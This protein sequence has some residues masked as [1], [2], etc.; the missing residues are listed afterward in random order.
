MKR[1]FLTLFLVIV[2]A[3]INESSFASVNI[4]WTEN[5]VEFIKNNPVINIGVDPQF[6]PFEFIDEDGNHA[7]IAA[8]YLELIS[9]LTG[10]KFKLHEDLS[11]VDAYDLAVEKKIDLL[12]AIGKTKERENYFRFSKPYYF[13]KRVLVTKQENSQISGIEDLDGHTVAVQKNS[14][15][16]SY[17]LDYNKI[18]LSLYN[19]VEAALTAVMTGEEIAF[20]GNLATTNYLIRTHGITD[21]RF[22]SFEA[23]HLQAL[24]FAVR[25]DWPILVDILDKAM[26]YISEEEKAD[27]K[28]KWI[29]IDTD[30]DYEPILKIVRIILILLAIVVI[31]SYF[32]IRRLQ[33]EINRRKTIQIELEGSNQKVYETNKQLSIANKELEKISMVD[34]LTNISNRRYFDNF[35]QKVWGINARESFPLALLMIDIDRFKNYNDKYGHLE[36]DKC[37]KEVAKEINNTVKRK[38][39]F[40]A[41]Y[42]GEEFVVLLSNTS[43]DGAIILAEKIRINIEDLVIKNDG[44]ASSV[45]VSIGV[46]SMIGVVDAPPNK[47]IEAADQALYQAKK[48]GRNRVV[49]FD[50]R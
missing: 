46:A 2:V 4:D 20:I 1:I 10:L 12:P 15:H 25:D 14:S 24:Y 44:L 33:S 47:L 3:S 23:E 13:F 45:T 17:L 16:H 11:W 37:L 30:Y 32:W 43:I 42:G 34:G 5:E 28:N 38:G 29:D 36:G 40:V 8:D 19:S 31:V 48:E 35:L 18:N 9:K 27:I 26:D 7:G 39:D 6:L 41:R 21:L 22:V 49:K 50:I